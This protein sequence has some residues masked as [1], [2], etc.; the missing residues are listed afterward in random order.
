M[1]RDKFLRYITLVLALLSFISCG[2]PNPAHISHD[3]NYPSWYANKTLTPHTKYEVLGYGEGVTLKEAKSN[4]KEDI[5]Q[6]LISKVESSFMSSSND[7]KTTTKSNLKV[8]SRL[9]LQNLKIVKQEQR[10][11]VFF[12]ALSY[13]NLD[14]AYRIK[15]TLKLSSCQDERVGVYIST[16]PLYKK[17]VS[18]IG[19]KLDFRLDRQNAAWYLKYKENKFLLNDDEF[20]EL[21][22]DRQNRSFSFKSSKRVLK[23]KES[24]YFTFNSKKSGYITLLDVYE[25]GIVTLLQPSIRITKTLQIPPKNSQNYFEAGLVQNGVDTYDLYVAIFSKKPLDMSRFEYANSDLASSEVAYKFDELIE[26]LDNY[27]YATI[28]LRTKAK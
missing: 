10:D 1:N 3:R 23:D 17:I 19:C 6:S 20:E 11:G 27:N 8:T 26:N 2:V 12:I 5:A 25:N 4:A 9:N 22:V 18:A 15:K 21:F 24:F 7:I 13:E 14:L 16:T 28:L